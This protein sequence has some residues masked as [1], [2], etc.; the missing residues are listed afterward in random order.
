MLVNQR[1]RRPIPFNYSTTPPTLTSP[2]HHLQLAVSLGVVMSF[3]VLAVAIGA[4]TTAFW[5][6][7]VA[8]SSSVKN[9]IVL[10]YLVLPMMS[11]MAF[12]AFSCDTVSCVD[13]RHARVTPAYNIPPTAEN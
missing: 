3:G 13:E 10:I 7:T 9:Y 12:S 4:A 6:G 1:I 2:P 5:G 11:T 8:R